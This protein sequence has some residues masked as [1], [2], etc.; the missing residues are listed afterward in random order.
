[1]KKTYLLLFFIYMLSGT[2]CKDD[3]SHLPTVNLEK[4]LSIN[5][6]RDSSYISDIRSL[7][8]YN[9]KYYASDYKRDQILILNENLELQK[10]LG[11]KGKGPGELL[12]AS[13]IYVYNDTIFVFNDSKRSF[14]LFNSEE[15]LQTIDLLSQ[16]SF[17]SG[18][19]FAVN[20]SEIYFSS[21]Y[22]QY[23]ISR[24]YYKLDSAQFFGRSTEYRTPRE[25]RIKNKRHVHVLDSKIVAIADCQPFID[26]YTLAGEFV[27]SFDLS[28]I[29]Q[30]KKIIEYVERNNYAE[31]SY[32]Q[33]FPESYVCEDNIFILIT[34]VGKN[35]EKY[36]N[37]LLELELEGDA[38]K[39]VRLLNLGDGWFKSFCISG[40]KIV[41]FNGSTAELIRYDY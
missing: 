32:F 33:F 25:S 8:Y 22:S 15:H 20:N 7:F 39:P 3:T 12:G 27:T 17:S 35:D 29:D 28:S 41:A 26:V 11:Q 5:Q 16:H 14:E 40:N 6:L 31:N 9:G 2:S 1:M 23:S 34:T 10:I 37:T 21:F 18:M 13:D 24:Y 19:R 4:D 38:I 36:K 30:I